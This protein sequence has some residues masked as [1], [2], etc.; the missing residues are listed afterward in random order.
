MKT[1]A[2]CKAT[3]A[4]FDIVKGYEVCPRCGW[5]KSYAEKRAATM[6]KDS[7]HRTVQKNDGRKKNLLK[8]IGDVTEKTVK[9]QLFADAM[10]YPP[11]LLPLAIS[12]ISVVYLLLLSP[13]LGNG[14]WA[15]IALVT[16]ILTAVIAFIRRFL[17]LSSEE[18]P[19]RIM[20]IKDRREREQA[21][22]EEARIR[23]QRLELESGF[24]TMNYTDGIS[25]LA[26]LTEE[27]DQL[28][29]VL[30]S[31]GETDP[32]SVA[33]FS[34]QVL[35][36]YKQG[37]SALKDAMELRKTIHPNDTRLS[38][39][40]ELFKKQIEKLEQNSGNEERIELRKKMV[41]SHMQRLELLDRLQLRVDT[42]IYQ[43][44]LCEAAL[45][46][47]RIELSSLKTQSSEYNIG[48][49]MDSL[50]GT[51]QDV[52]EAREE[53]RRIIQ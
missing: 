1:C 27:Y 10:Q 24:S 26:N 5:E 28:Q 44:G 40:L 37:M 7:G 53:I 11:A 34:S 13:V 45:N 19:R 22:K 35:D 36:T 46:S 48:L 8:K 41:S 3:F 4:E 12:G 21:Q 14:L 42:L 18:F 39:E 31:T 16:G 43:A 30:I 51:I 25:A 17:F 32:V 2:F 20:E 9:R 50:Q 23:K 29:H 52:K 47:T 49:L 38:M 33:L 6:L 15:V